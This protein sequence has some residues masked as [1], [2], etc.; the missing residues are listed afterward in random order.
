[1]QF[2]LN[3]IC[4][5]STIRIYNFIYWHNLVMQPEFLAS[6][7][8]IMSKVLFRSVVDPPQSIH[9]NVLWQL[10]SWIYRENANWMIKY[11]SI[12]HRNSGHNLFETSDYLDSVY[13]LHQLS[14]IYYR[15]LIS[16]WFCAKI[17]FF[18]NFVNNHIF[19]L[20]HIEDNIQ[21]Q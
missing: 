21:S 10:I 7:P 8:N 14:F 9:F 17:T 19:V 3:N 6:T 5:Q 15:E 4:K 20:R 1:M 16:V 12:S 13:G 18:L 2:A 11:L